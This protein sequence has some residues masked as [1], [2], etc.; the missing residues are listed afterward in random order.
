MNFI[1]TFFFAVAALW[2]F[3]ASADPAWQQYHSTEGGYS[4]DMPIPVKEGVKDL[5]TPG[6][7]MFTASTSYE[8]GAFIVSMSDLNPD[9]LPKGAEANLDFLRDAVL[10]AMGA[11]AANEKS[12]KVGQYP[13][14]RFDHSGG[15]FSGT[16][17]IILV[18]RHIYQMYALGPEGFAQTP[19]ALRFLN[20]FA[21]T[22]K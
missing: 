15:R 17:R 12:E 21:L 6:E 7:K 19:E 22:A 13:A 2:T 5:S 10:T 18:N 14:R 16:M 1:R 4:V 8:K 11:K 3:T 20:S 9:R